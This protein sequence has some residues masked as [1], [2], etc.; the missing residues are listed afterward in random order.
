MFLKSGSEA[1]LV[2]HGNG[3]C[4]EPAMEFSTYA[5][6]L[7]IALQLFAQFAYMTWPYR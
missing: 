3:F 1:V 6:W 5:N 7:S 4:T 2:R